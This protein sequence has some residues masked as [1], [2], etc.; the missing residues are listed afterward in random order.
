MTERRRAIVGIDPG[1]TSAV[2]VLDL[3]GNLKELYS[4]KHMG[5]EGLIRKVSEEGK[6]VLITTDKKKLPSTVEEIANSFGAETFTPE[7]DLSVHSKRELTRKD[8][9]EDLHQRDA[10]ASALKAYNS[11]KNK[12][13]NIEARMDD[14]NLQDLTPEIKELVVKEEAKNVSEAVEMALGEEE[15]NEEGKTV[16]EKQRNE[17][18]EEKM[19][20]YRQIIMQERE[21]KEK[22][23]E[24]NEKLKEEVEKLKN[25]VEKLEKDKQ[26]LEEG[27]RKEVIEKKEVKK[28]ERNL[29]SKKNRIQALEKDVSEL[30][31]EINELKTF[32]ELRKEGKVP[33]REVTELSTEELRKENKELPLDGSVLIINGLT[34]D[35]EDIAELLK[36]F[37]VKGVIGGI[38]PDK[39]DYL[40][41]ESIWA[42]SKENI[43]VKKKGG[44]RYVDWEDVENMK[45]EGKRSLMGWLRRYRGR[46]D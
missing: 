13:Q 6:P 24:H 40:I 34:D 12:F 39:I 2:A 23:K 22:V 29:R 28:L 27:I 5:K 35:K 10:L 21:D 43:E 30:K 11:F 25:K 41:S 18:L 26:D 38:D 14:L 15:D 1:S 36:E 33:L 4:E 17:D 20:N 42:C 7:E 32:E 31:E 46:D 37:G 44:V 45:K 8:D 9:Y 16:T 3:K 19:D